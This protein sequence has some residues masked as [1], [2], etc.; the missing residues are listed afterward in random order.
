MRHAMPH[1]RDS[2]SFRNLQFLGKGSQVSDKGE[3]YCK[4][5]DPTNQNKFEARS[6]MEQSLS[7][8]AKGLMYKV[9]RICVAQFSVISKLIALA[10]YL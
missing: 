2:L 7:F 1:L 5:T 8:T 3:G 10:F 6:G 4:A 9:I